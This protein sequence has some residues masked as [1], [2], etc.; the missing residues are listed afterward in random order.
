[1]QGIQFRLLNRKKGPAVQ[2]PRTQADRALYRDGIQDLT[3]KRSNLDILEGEVVDLTLDSGNVNGVQLADGS[4][5]SAKAVVL[6]SGT[7]LRGGH[8]YWRCLPFWWANG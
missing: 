5:V 1:M 2:G 4:T 8:P 3:A 7:F 6:T